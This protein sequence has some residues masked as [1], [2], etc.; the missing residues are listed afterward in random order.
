MTR[1]TFL[2]ISLTVLGGALVLAGLAT[3]LRLAL[4]CGLAGFA[5]AMFLNFEN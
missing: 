4:L 1:L 2:R 5:A 3:G